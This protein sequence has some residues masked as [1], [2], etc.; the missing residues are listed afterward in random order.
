LRA[1]DRLTTLLRRGAALRA[2]AEVLPAPPLLEDDAA[3]QREA[4]ALRPFVEAVAGRPYR[5]PA[6]VAYRRGLEARIFG[7]LSTYHPLGLARVVR[8]G[9]LEGR[10]F[11]VPTLLA[12]ELAHRYS[13]DESITTLRG[14]EAS[15]RRAEAGD[16][17]HAVSV[18]ISLARLAF[19]SACSLAADAGLDED[20]ESFLEATP[21]LRTPLGEAWAAERARARGG[22]RV[23]G[24]ALVY[25]ILPT[26]A[27]ERAVA[28]GRDCAEHLPFPG[29]TL[30]SARSVGT[31][32]A[33]VLDAA[34][35]RRRTRIPL[36]AVCRLWSDA[37][38][39][40]A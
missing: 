13:F 1:R 27:L 5:R 24:L 18:R 21:V 6:H 15:A 32:G 34:M 17:G 2:S 3:L 23:D 16:A 36:D 31:L 33:T 22:R 39:R 7:D 28:D 8:L 11:I 40:P 35:G 25:S 12:H 26:E 29:M 20:V 37:D 30:R 9:R 14:L 19:V 10:R 4:E 38:G